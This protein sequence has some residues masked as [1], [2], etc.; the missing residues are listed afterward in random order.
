MCV[1]LPLT[2][3]A[4]SLFTCVSTSSSNPAAPLTNVTLPLDG[5]EVVTE[6]MMADF[7]DPSC[8]DKVAN[9][10]THSFLAADTRIECWNGAHTNWAVALGVPM[11]VFFVLGVPLF[12]YV[13]LRPL[14]HNLDD[15]RGTYGFLHVLRHPTPP[16][17]LHMLACLP[18]QKTLT[19]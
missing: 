19:Q 15:W 12:G 5:G 1:Q 17:L 8:D 6:L 18:P 3:T 10:G 11:V 2:K 7:F 16:H 13:V 9:Y 14:R 4:L